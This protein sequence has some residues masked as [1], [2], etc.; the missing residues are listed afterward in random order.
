MP[1][2]TSV[3][4]GP[5]RFRASTPAR[6]GECSCEGL[7]ESIGDRN[8]VQSGKAFNNNHLPASIGD[9]FQ[10]LAGHR[11]L[12]QGPRSASVFSP[13]IERFRFE[14]GSGGALGVRRF[15]YIR[16]TRP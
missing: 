2:A 4:V 12:R 10:Q 15:E 8:P 13:E 6:G 11:L 9:S 14:R 7:R 5:T 3:A 1:H 16:S